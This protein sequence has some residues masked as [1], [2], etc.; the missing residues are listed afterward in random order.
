M[1][2]HRCPV[3]TQPRPHT[4]RERARA[5]KR[6]SKRERESIPP[7]V[8][9]IHVPA[10][11]HPLHL[12]SLSPMPTPVRYAMI[13]FLSKHRFE[14]LKKKLMVVM[15]FSDFLAIVPAMIRRWTLPNKLLIDPRFLDT[16]R[17]ATEIVKDGKVGGPKGSEGSAT[18]ASSRL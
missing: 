13:V 10:P 16:L 4:H 18:D 11:A 1:L 9:G 7:T 14:T 5:R 12:P 15:G 17:A 8:R 2:G 3:H 6:A